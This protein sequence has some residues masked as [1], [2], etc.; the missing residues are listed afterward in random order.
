MCFI[1]RF[2]KTLVSKTVAML[3]I[4]YNRSIYGECNVPVLP[5]RSQIL[6]FFLNFTMAFPCVLFHNDR[7]IIFGMK[8]K[9]KI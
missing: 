9:T 3:K 8:R 5:N 4:V 7:L 1:L 6:N 2:C